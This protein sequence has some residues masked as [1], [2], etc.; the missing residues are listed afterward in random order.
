MAVDQRITNILERE[1]VAVLAVELPDGPHA[2]A[3]H[4]VYDL[5]SRNIYF[6]TRNSSKKVTAVFP[7]KASVVVGFSETDWETVQIRGT[8]D[9]V[10]E[11]E[12]KERLVAKY[13]GDAK[14]LGPESVYLKF[15]SSWW[16]Y[17]DFK[18]QPLV[19]LE[20]Q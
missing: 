6:S 5:D 14:H 12:A 2:A 20:G 15:T 16:R 10:G 7:A 11:K 13:S 8:I 18:A 9:K 17:T 3:M 1:K 4:F 19:M